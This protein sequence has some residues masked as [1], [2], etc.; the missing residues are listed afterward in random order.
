MFN[1][2]EKKHEIALSRQVL[3]LEL[4]TDL[5]EITPSLEI[6]AINPVYSRFIKCGDGGQLNHL[7]T[8]RSL[9]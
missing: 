2:G 9:L 5:L 7:N 1:R 8:K 6:P 3:Y 4:R